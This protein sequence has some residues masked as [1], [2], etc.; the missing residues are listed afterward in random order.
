M[1]KAGGGGVG[2]LMAGL[3]PLGTLAPRV[4]FLEMS[5]EVDTFSEGFFAAKGWSGFCVEGL[6]I[7]G[8]GDWGIGRKTAIGVSNTKKTSTNL[9]S[10]FFTLNSY[11]YA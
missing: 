2:W 6:A 1:R 9:S 3:E 11:Y 5:W 8:R 10:P 7:L 4:N